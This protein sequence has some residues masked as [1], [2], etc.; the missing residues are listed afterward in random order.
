MVRGAWASSKFQ[1]HP[2]LLRAALG[3][4]TCPWL[5]IL[6]L[7]NTIFASPPVGGSL[8]SQKD[9]D[10][11]RASTYSLQFRKAAIQEEMGTIE[12]GSGFHTSLSL[13]EGSCPMSQEKISVPGDTSQC[14]AFPESTTLLMLSREVT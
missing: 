6:L 5:S 2:P 13:P 10:S 8:S 9:L 11:T 14:P 1:C 3:T 12:T 7:D 4:P